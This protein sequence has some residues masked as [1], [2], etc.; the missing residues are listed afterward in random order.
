MKVAAEKG[1]RDEGVTSRAHRY[2]Y[3]TWGYQPD[4]FGGAERQAKAQA[5]E[6][7]RRRHVV[8][9]VCPRWRGTK[10]SVAQG[11]DVR[12]LRFVQHRP[13]TS[14]SYSVALFWF[15]LKRAHHFD[16]IYVH[17]AYFQADAAV[18]AALIRGRPVVVKVAASGEHGEIAR[19]KRLGWAAATRL[20]GLRMAT[21]VQATSADIEQEVISVG[22]KRDR[23]LTMPNG[24]DTSA[25]RPASPEEKRGARARLG[26]P[27]EGLITLFVGRLARHKGVNDLL[28]VWPR[29]KQSDSVLVLVG[30]R[31]TMDS[32]DP[33]Q[34][35]D[36]V[37][38]REWSDD[39]TQYYHAADIFVLP[40]YVEG[41]S[42][43]MLEAMA[44][45][46]AVV[47]TRVG[48]AEC[49][50]EDGVSGRLICAGDTDQLESALREVMGSP[51]A[52][53]QL[54]EKARSRIEVGFSLQSVVNR[55]ETLAGELAVRR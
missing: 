52:R 22:V 32:V 2:L 21:R 10:S 37:I 1:T 38:V 23:I 16:L 20:I 30:S 17:H 13:Y 53:S 18:L 29:L 19:M 39:I 41:M 48:A 26:L 49:V 46:L 8:T 12:R 14:A 28:S 3:C 34:S 51:A 35:S 55:I 54:G 33:L 44:C 31:T 5:E 6:L 15:L 36:R 45:G 4:E 25:F 27:G 9:V 40:S 47:S 11:V 43:A 7:A 50:L 42:N 24:V